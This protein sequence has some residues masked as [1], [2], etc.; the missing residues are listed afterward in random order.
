M[1]DSALLPNNLVVVRV[2][3]EV[4][5]LVADNL[6]VPHDLLLR[7]DLD[8]QVLVLQCRLVLSVNNHAVPELIYLAIAFVILLSEQGTALQLARVSVPREQLR[9]LRQHMQVRVASCLVKDGVHLLVRTPE[10]DSV[11]REIWDHRDLHWAPVDS[12]LAI[13]LVKGHTE[14]V[15]GHSWRE[16]L[17]ARKKL[18]KL[19]DFVEVKMAFGRGVDV[20][21]RVVLHHTEVLDHG[22]VLDVATRDLGNHLHVGVLRTQCLALNLVLTRKILKLIFLCFQNCLLCQVE[23]VDLILARDVEEVFAHALPYD[24]C[25]VHREIRDLAVRQEGTVAACLLTDLRTVFVRLLA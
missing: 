3:I 22:R 1:L 4:H 5:F 8:A 7:D 12:D 16:N 13:L 2:D 20:S 15:A 23:L 19:A 9:L 6:G 14:A 11:A 24:V 10:R 17:A 25:Y 21:R 18:T